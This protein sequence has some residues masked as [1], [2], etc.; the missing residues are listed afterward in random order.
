VNK[1]I[2]SNPSSYYQPEVRTQRT[3]THITN[4]H[5]QH[6]SSWYYSQPRVYVG[7]GYDSA[8]WWMMS[9]WSAE[10][11]AQWFYHNQNVIERDAYERGMRD[12]AVASHVAELKAQNTKINSDYVDPEFVK[13]PSL[14]YTQDHIEAVYNPEVATGNGLTIFLGIVIVCVLLVAAWFVLFRIRWGN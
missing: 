11:R 6:P 14:M 5:Y 10:R 1:T 7:G 2:R 12:A 8:F 4:Y 3:E 13:D 9:E